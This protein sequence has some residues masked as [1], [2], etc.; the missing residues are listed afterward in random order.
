MTS[1]P[2]R[3]QASSTSPG[4]PPQRERARPG[5]EKM[6]DPITM[7]VRR[8]VLCCVVLPFVCQADMLQIYVSCQHSHLPTMMAMPSPT[9]SCPVRAAGVEGITA[10]AVKG[11][12]II[13]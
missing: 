2:E 10:L 9:P 11:K 8:V 13:M 3:L 5:D 1:T 4:E 7:P 6:P 12:I